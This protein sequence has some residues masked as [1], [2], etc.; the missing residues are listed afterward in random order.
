[1]TSPPE[2]AKLSSTD[3][4][5]RSEVLRTTDGAPGSVRGRFNRPA[6]I[7]YVAFLVL[8]LYGFA[9]VYWASG[10]DGF[11]FGADDA[12]PEYSAFEHLSRGQLAPW[13]AGWFLGSAVVAL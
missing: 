11:P 12:N 6:L 5:A 4:A 1:M 9:H 10:G 2:P 3:F 13:I 8:L 7:G